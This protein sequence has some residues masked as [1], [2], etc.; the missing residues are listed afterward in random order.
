[1]LIQKDIFLRAGGFDEDFF[2]YYE[3][4]DLGWRLWVLGYKVI[5]VPTSIVYHAHHG[6]S[7]NFGDDK[8]RFLRERNALYAIFKNYDDDHMPYILAA[9]LASIFSRI[10]VDTSLTTRKY[11]DLES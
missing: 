9:T 10:F 5:F 4:V 1:M 2:A 11:Y 7:K 8:L 3:D 6:T